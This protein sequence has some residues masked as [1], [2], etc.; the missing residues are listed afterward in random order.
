MIIPDIN[1]LLYAYSADSDWHAQARDWF[2]SAMAGTEPLGLPW[3][4]ILGFVR[5][6]TNARARRL[7]LRLVDAME[8]VETWLAQPGVTVLQPGMRHWGLLRDLAQRCAC[9]GPL[10]SDA[11]L[12]ALAIENGALLC[13]T[14]QDFSRFPG[15]R[16][17]NPLG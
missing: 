10:M 3:H 2:Q 11:H 1:L 6:S 5:I 17:Q 8:V 14:D 13:S 12:A 7:P 4:V 16:W 9:S 15:L